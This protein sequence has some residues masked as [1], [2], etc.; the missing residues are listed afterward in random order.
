MEEFEKVEEKCIKLNR[1]PFYWIKSLNLISADF[2]IF[3]FIN[4]LQMYMV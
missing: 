1:H 4:N 2:P 3:H